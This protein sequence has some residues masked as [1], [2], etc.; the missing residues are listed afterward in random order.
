MKRSSDR[1]PKRTPA[2]SLI[3]LN[4][5]RP[6]QKPRQVTGGGRPFRWPKGRKWRFWLNASLAIIF[7]ET[8]IYGANGKYEAADTFHF[9]CWESIFNRTDRTVR[10]TVLSYISE[11][12]Y[13]TEEIRGSEPQ[14]RDLLMSLL[15]FIY[16]LG[17]KKV[18]RNR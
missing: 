12:N 4:I 8:D 15:I 11:F 3:P 7:S 6:F 18:V 17:E 13:L 14:D 9:V 10:S 5:A 16:F 1:R 2:E